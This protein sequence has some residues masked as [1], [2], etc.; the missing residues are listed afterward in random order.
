MTVLHTESFVAFEAVNSTDDTYTTANT[1]LR[2][3]VAAN[4]RRAGY[5][6]SVQAQTSATTSAGFAIRPDPVNPDR[7]ALFFSAG[8]QSNAPGAALR[9]LMPQ[10]NNEAIIGGF[11]LYI[12]PEFVKLPTPAL[13]TASVF[14]MFGAALSDT[15]SLTEAQNGN[16]VA[17]REIFRVLSD[18]RIC[19]NTDAPQSQKT[20]TA[21]RIN[22]IEY[23]LSANDIR[24]WVDDVLVLQKNLGLN[25]ETIGFV[26]DQASIA[27]PGTNL[28]GAPGRW[29]LGNWY[30]LLED[31]FA[32]N[33][34]L[35]PTTR[36]IGV[37]P[38]T[39]VS[40]MFQRPT[41]YASNAAVVASN[42][43]DAPPAT[44]QSTS[45][46]D[47]D[48]YRS[49]TDTTTASGKLI[50]AV[51]V[52]VLASNLESAPHAIRPLVRSDTGVESTTPK[53]REWRSLGAISTKQLN[54]VA[55]RP[56][57]GKIFAVGNSIA[58][59]VNSQEGAAG[60]P[61]TLISDDGG[62]INYT[63]IAFRADGWGLI[64]RSDGKLQAIPPG[65]DVP[66]AP[67]TPAGQ[68]TST[69]VN[70]IYFLPNGR[71]LIACNGSRM[72][73]GQIGANS[74]ID[75]AA[76]YTAVTVGGGSS[77]SP[78]QITFS[79]TLGTGN[80]RVF[81]ATDASSGYANA[82]RSDDNGVTWTGLYNNLNMVFATATWDAVAGVFIMASHPRADYIR[83]S[84]D[85]ITWSGTAAGSSTNGTNTGTP[86][87]QITENGVTTVLGPNGYMVTSTNGGTDWRPIR[88]FTFSVRALCVAANGDYIGVGD[89]GQAVAYTAGSPDGALAPLG[90][91]VPYYNAT[92]LNPATGA[93]WTPAEASASQFGMRL[94]S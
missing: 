26:F 16:G 28:V 1:N 45:V 22:F 47:Q 64:G 74:V 62:A 86:L 29:S 79:P 57:D 59:L 8:G 34:R 36:V 42:L 40:T 60:T 56:T 94:T 2:N 46:G 37:R 73:Y 67:I 18:L 25:V 77:G 44:L 33:V 61:W 68:T 88:P 11:S 92:P 72:L 3:A 50:H 65:A 41:G 84:T 6:V 10:V 39:D 90:G 55:R 17:M 83:R 70:H 35:G 21:G 20:L 69:P 19:W 12:P 54:G 49:T 4:L 23:R 15:L 27:S 80:G 93:A 13:S 89:N 53:S 78:R 9:K 51:A 75:V 5:L 30:N 63:A 32:P 71:P 52:K 81:A 38:N 14:R 82:Y 91:Y 76:N 58:L 31:A 7:N 87:G 85:G 66:S 43:V 24:V 48:I